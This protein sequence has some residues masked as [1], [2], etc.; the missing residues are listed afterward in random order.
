VVPLL[1]GFPVGGNGFSGDAA[2]RVAFAAAG[3]ARR[4]QAEQ[5]DLLRHGGEHC[6]PEHGIALLHRSGSGA[7][8]DAA[9]D[10]RVCGLHGGH[11]FLQ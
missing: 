6:H 4:P 5:E 11:D 9:G 3:G 1:W 10:H 7:A 8:G 2:G